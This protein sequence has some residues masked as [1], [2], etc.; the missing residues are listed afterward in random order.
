MAVSVRC[1]MRNLRVTT[2]LI[3][4]WLLVIAMIG[5]L[6]ITTYN[7]HQ[8]NKRADTMMCLLKADFQHE[9]ASVQLIRRMA[10]FEHLVA[11]YISETEPVKR[12][13]L[14]EQFREPPTLEQ[15]VAEVD[16]ALA[17]TT[18]PEC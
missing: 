18:A 5:G 1:I 16:A 12:E 9:H 14:R 11:E 4:L 10:V 15:V 2:D 7:N 13:L 17:K 3:V 6:L 8:T